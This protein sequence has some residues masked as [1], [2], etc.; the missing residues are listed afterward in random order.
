MRIRSLI[1]L[2]T[3]L[4]ANLSSVESAHAGLYAF[5]TH[6][7]TSCGATGRSGPAQSSCTSSYS[8]APWATNSSFFSVTNG[9]QSWKVP[10]TGTYTL[11]IFGASGGASTARSFAGGKGARVQTTVSLTEG[12][13]IKI[14]VGQVGGSFS[15][16][17]GGGGGTFIYNQTIGA[18]IAV[19]GGGGGGG[20]SGGAGYSAST[21]TS[22]NGS[23]GGY[24]SG[25]SGIGGSASTG[26]GWGFS[27]AGI[28]GDGQGGGSSYSYST[29]ANALSF[30]NGGTGAG[31]SG[32]DTTASCVGAW[33]GFGGGGGGQC[34]GGGGGGGYSGGAAGGGGGGSY[35]TGSSTSISV[36]STSDSAKVIITATSPVVMD[37]TP[38]VITGPGASTGAS[39][40]ISIAENST[41]VTTFQVNETS[42][43]SIS[44]TDSTFFSIGSS[45]GVLTITARD[46]ETRAD[47]NQ[48]NVYLVIVT[49]TDLNSNATSQ[50][51]SVTITNINE[52][53]SISTNSSAATYSLSLNENNSTVAT[54]SGTDV[55]SGTTLGFSI[56]GTDSG[57]FHIG[58]SNG[59]LQFLNNPDYELPVDSDAN[60]VYVVQVILS[61]GSLVDTQTITITITN[62]T[63][64]LVVAAPT[65]SANPKKGMPVTVSLVVDSSAQVMFFANGKRIS[66]CKIR[67]TSGVYPNNVATC[68]WK[69]T[70]TG[71]VVLTA[72]VDPTLAGFATVTSPAITIYVER[73]TN[74]R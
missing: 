21:T 13:V 17:G 29:G 7:F 48:D 15:Y 4:L 57:D 16:T 65:L 14:L 68:V 66:S 18:A 50:T 31:Q 74:Q 44:G 3:L 67:I 34:N 11:D 41:S 59:V 10:G 12:H 37:A 23:W 54:F 39:S 8:A 70:F 47:A 60:N 20:D 52:A 53:P 6:T 55:D 27:G 2:A 40:S 43:W 24:A 22:G 38:P 49:A 64:N 35:V 25:T 63:E 33:G 5:T 36:I 73:R 56:S 32:T 19:A 1:V 61:D 45:S 71:R 69:P 42:T 62:V 9:I 28:N 51:L 72:R 30:T 46:F 58:V 26:S